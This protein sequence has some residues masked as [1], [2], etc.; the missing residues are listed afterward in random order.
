MNPIHLLYTLFIEV[1][2]KEYYMHTVE[3]ANDFYF[4]VFHY[5]YK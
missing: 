5:Q 4:V 3:Y 2:I 1:D